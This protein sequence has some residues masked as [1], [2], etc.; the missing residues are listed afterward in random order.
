M[1]KLFF[2]LSALALAGICTQSSCTFKNEEDTYGGVCD[3]S[4]VTLSGTVRPILEQN[5]YACHS[6]ANANTLGAGIELQNYSSIKDFIDGAGNVFISA[7]RQE[8]YNGVTAS[9]MPKGMPRISSCEIQQ[10]EKWIAAG[11]PDN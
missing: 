6:V 5:C 2:A 9:P 1:K 4:G 10:I 11:A 7:L 8:E 3:T